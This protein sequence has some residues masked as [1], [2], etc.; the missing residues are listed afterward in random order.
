MSEKFEGFE[1]KEEEKEIDLTVFKEYLPGA[2]IK[3]IDLSGVPEDVL[4]YF[5]EQSKQIFS[6]EMENYKPGN[7]NKIF[8]V[9][10]PDAQ[11][12]YL[13]NQ[14]KNYPGVNNAKEPGESSYLADVSGGGRCCG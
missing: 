4:K 8:A 3:A 11:T 9:Q 10:Y 6:D 14:T 2:D 7:F 1:P 13:A 5:E 12:T